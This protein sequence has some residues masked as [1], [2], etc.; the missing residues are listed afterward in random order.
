[1]VIHMH[2]EL[3]SFRI[4]VRISLLFL[5]SRQYMQENRILQCNL[6]KVQYVKRKRGCTSACN[7]SRNKKKREWIHQLGNDDVP[8][9]IPE[10]L[11]LYV[12]DRSRLLLAT[13]AVRHGFKLIRLR[14]LHFSFQLIQPLPTFIGV[15][16]C[17]VLLAASV[18]MYIS[19]RVV[20]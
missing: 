5:H 17:S 19:L 8:R 11:G 15:H 1:M 3:A 2:V 14:G 16:I 18:Y 9:R 7:G 20:F 12:K 6:P 13:T 10:S 4:N